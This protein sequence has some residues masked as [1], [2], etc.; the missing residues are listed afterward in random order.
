[1][2]ARSRQQSEHL[3]LS[4]NYSALL[5][6][7]SSLL[8]AA[9]DNRKLLP[10]PPEAMG[11]QARAQYDCSRRQPQLSL[12]H[13]TLRRSSLRAQSNSDFHSPVFEMKL[14][15]GKHARQLLSLSRAGRNRTRGAS[16]LRTARPVSYAGACPPVSTSPTRQQFARRL[17]ADAAMPSKLLM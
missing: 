10:S 17:P 12:A 3:A 4:P 7:R 5:P 16:S 1:R 14:F 13:S 11:Q 9:R 6:P 8:E 15:H 2:S